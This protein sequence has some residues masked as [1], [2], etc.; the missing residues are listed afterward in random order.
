[1]TSLPVDGR[2]IHGDPGLPEV[3]KVFSD[4]LTYQVNFAGDGSVPR[5]AMTLWSPQRKPWVMWKPSAR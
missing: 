2:P 5:P 1:M 3:L 4:L